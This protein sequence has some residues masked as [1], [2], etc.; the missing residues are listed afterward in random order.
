[1]QFGWFEIHDTVDEYY[2]DKRQIV[3]DPVLLMSSLHKQLG[4]KGD[5]IS[6]I[7]IYEDYYDHQTI[8]KIVINERKY[9][10]AKIITPD[11]NLEKE[12][13]AIIRDRYTM[14]SPRIDISIE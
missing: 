7:E 12:I 10:M 6:D 13:P 8:I 3:W 4:P 11:L 2:D 1:M 9:L 5:A 14:L